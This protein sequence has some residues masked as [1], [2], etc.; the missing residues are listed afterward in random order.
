MMTCFAVLAKTCSNGGRLY[1]HHSSAIHCIFSGRSKQIGYWPYIGQLPPGKGLGQLKQFGMEAFL[2]LQ[3]LRHRVLQR[4][5]RCLT[6]SSCCCGI[7]QR[8]CC[9][10]NTQMRFVQNVVA[11]LVLV[12][13]VSLAIAAG[14]ETICHL[15]NATPLPIWRSLK[16]PA[17]CDPGFYCPNLVP[18]QSCPPRKCC[19][20][21]IL[22]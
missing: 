13:S 17:S 20:H 22:A 1:C 16:N 2:E 6:I 8:R 19:S 5:S 21:G 4:N 7:R 12:A 3:S 10:A 11:A 18:G 14:D 15:P 9:R